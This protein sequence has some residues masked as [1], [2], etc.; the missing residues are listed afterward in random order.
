MPKGFLGFG[1]LPADG[2][3]A[4]PAAGAV[5]GFAW[6]YSSAI[7]FLGPRGAVLA[8]VAGAAFLGGLTFTNLVRQS[9]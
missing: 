3:L 6:G 8:G 2:S 7:V 1:V 5:L 9:P 4:L